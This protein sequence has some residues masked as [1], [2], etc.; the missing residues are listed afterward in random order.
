MCDRHPVESW[1]GRR[2]PLAIDVFSGVGGLSLGLEQA[3]F[4]VVAALEY[5]PV[6]AAAHK[7]NFPDAEVL[8]RDA[9]K[10]GADLLLD[11]A[12]RG[13]AQLDG[14]DAADGSCTGW[15]R[16]V[17]ALVG[18]PPCQGFSTGGKREQ[19]DERNGLIEHFVR[20]V[21]E[22]RPA[23]FCLE[24]VSGLL[25][26]RFDALRERVLR[27]LRS[28]GYSITGIEEPIDAYDYGVPQ[29]RRRV[30]VLGSLGGDPGRP[31]PASRRV[32]VADALDGLPDPAN[33]SALL[34]QDW[35][36]LRVSDFE[37]LEAA[38]SPYARRL[39][40]LES[41]AQDMSP[42][43]DFDRTLLTASKFTVHA[44]ASIKR[45]SA[46]PQGAVEAV[47]RYYRLPVDGP[48][49]TL[50]AGTGAERG[51]HTSPR[52]IHPTAPRV[53]TAREA[54]RLHGYPDWFRFHVTNWHAHRQIGNSVPPP[55]ARAAGL[56]LMKALGAVPVSANR[57]VSLPD[58]RLLS[59][60][61]SEA[62]VQFDAVNDE[63]PRG[64]ARTA[65]AA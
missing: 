55:L 4:D 11:A 45:F 22:V 44:L 52:P 19:D 12:A 23:T 39:C 40:G 37:A 54:A 65:S 17:D 46:T 9:S 47:S 33:Y 41:D 24:N 62:S 42:T 51:A 63:L 28:A 2:R 57:T 30:I 6:H 25:E 5:D 18:G 10:V 36:R 15:N 8:C 60:S 16:R 58:E 48:A 1:S 32:V 35:A 59:L 7:Y 13:L 56:A 29:R 26:P 64:R 49:R 53:I 43:R 50:R 31:I 20:L 3:G 61:K 27:R 38:S 34:K 21:E 14:M